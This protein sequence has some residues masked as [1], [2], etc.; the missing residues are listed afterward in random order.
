MTCG[1]FQTGDGWDAPVELVLCER[2]EAEEAQAI[3]DEREEAQ[4]GPEPRCLCG[5]VMEI[6]SRGDHWCRSCC[7]RHG[8]WMDFKDGRAYE[9]GR[10]L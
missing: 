10:K 5:A 3:Q 1:C 4:L 8:V 7:L 6:L 9:R 2:H